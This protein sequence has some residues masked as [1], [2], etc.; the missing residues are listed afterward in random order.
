MIA[1]FTSC[2]NEEKSDFLSQEAQDNATDYKDYVIV[3]NSTSK[4]VVLL[5]P[6][7]K[8]VRDLL[9]LKKS[10]TEYPWGLAMLD[11][12]NLL[13][14]VEGVDRIMSTNLNYGANS[15]YDFIIDTNYTSNPVRGLAVL[16]SGEI[17]ASEQNTVEKFNS[18]GVRITAGGWPKSL[19]T[20]G[21]QLSAF[22]NG[23]FIYCS[24]G[25]GVVRSYDSMAVQTASASSGIS[26]TNAV[27]GCAVGPSGQ[28]VASF[29]GTTDTI[30]MYTD[31]T[32]TTVL[33]SYSDTTTLPNPTAVGI[34]SNGNVI[35]IDS[36]THVIVEIDG[37]T[38]AF[39][40]SSS[41][42]SVVGATSLLIVR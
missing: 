41:S 28:V 25:T 16:A 40:N 24:I 17:L 18:S 15:A 32:L 29:N 31:S 10:T 11:K 34:R 2:S 14:S 1:F 9:V 37:L 20:T 36:T 21:T 23:G 7:L 38:G 35:V 12:H 42:S 19:Q 8:Y 6:Q 39:I 27:Y 33:W 13:V 22:P 26:G 30:R 3:A 4:S 5:D